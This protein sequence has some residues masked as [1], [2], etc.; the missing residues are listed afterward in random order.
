[1]GNCPCNISDTG[2]TNNKKLSC[3]ESRKN[4]TDDKLKIDDDSIDIFDLYLSD[5][6]LIVDTV[7]ED[8]IYVTFGTP[9]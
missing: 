4:K 1:M 8:D 9:T 3:F 2:R 5:V 6:D 7:F